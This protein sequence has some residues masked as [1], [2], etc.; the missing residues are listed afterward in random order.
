MENQSQQKSVIISGANGYFGAIAT[1]YFHDQ[2]WQVLQATRQD[3]ADIYFNLDQPEAFSQHKITTNVDL[4]IHAAAAHE[5]DCYHHPY[6][7]ICQNIV[8]TKAALEFCLAN[9]IPRFIYL[10]TFHVFGY[11]QGN[12]DENTKPFPKNDYGLSHLQAEEYVYM[13]NREHNLNGTVIRPSNFFGIPANLEQF[14]RWSLTPL[15]FCHEAVISQKITL[16]TPG[17]QKRNFISILDICAAIHVI[18]AKS[19]DLPLLHLCGPDTLSIRELACLIKQIM[20]EHFQRNVQLIIPEGIPQQIDF[21]YSSCSLQ[22]IYQPH[23]S[24]KGFVINF[25]QELLYPMYAAYL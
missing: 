16:K 18:S 17:F 20:N 21:N 6:R 14:Q 19:F 7:S 15:A 4:F 9:N 12:I 2:G 24:L 1:Q 10:S 13:Y 5:L 11:P 25:C 8:G 23:Y 3:T 22:N